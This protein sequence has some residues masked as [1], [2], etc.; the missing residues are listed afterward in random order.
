MRAP[1]G[2][3]EGTQDSIGFLTLS[4]TNCYKTRI[5]FHDSATRRGVRKSLA[6]ILDTSFPSGLRRAKTDHGA[7]RLSIHISS[8][9]RDISSLSEE[10][11]P[12]R[13]NTALLHET[14][15]ADQ[16]A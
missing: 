16:V 2:S 13:W 11:V 14:L 1:R 5:Q 15:Q 12:K 6:V 3:L 7:A 9:G 10:T 4:I 8:R